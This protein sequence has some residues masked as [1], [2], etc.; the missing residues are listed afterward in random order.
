MP[1]LEKKIMVITRSTSGIGLAS[2]QLFIDE[3]DRTVLALL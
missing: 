1:K 3:I 2:A